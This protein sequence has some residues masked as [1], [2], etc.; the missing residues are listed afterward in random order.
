MEIKYTLPEIYI[1]YALNENE[2]VDRI[3]RLIVKQL[4]HQFDTSKHTLVY[5]FD[6]LS[7]KDSIEEYFERMAKSGYIVL[8]IS[9]LH[10]KSK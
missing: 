5:D 4:R 8:I 6:S 2:E 3:K 7:Y 10:L 1:S 9:D